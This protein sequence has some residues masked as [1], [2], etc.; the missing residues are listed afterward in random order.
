MQTSLEDV[1]GMAAVSRLVV[2]AQ[3]SEK[4]GKNNGN[5]AAAV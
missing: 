1:P 5:D 3:S 2:I 4:G